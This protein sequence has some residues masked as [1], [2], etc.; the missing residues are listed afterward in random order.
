MARL[1]IFDAHVTVGHRWLEELATKLRIPLAEPQR[2]VLA[3]RAGLHAI[4]DRLPA[5]EVLDLGAQMPM[6]IR[7]LY[8]EGW[9]LRNDPTKI[10]T[11]AQLVER[12]AR[13]LR[14][15][16]R[17]DPVDVLRAVIELLSEHISAGELADVKATLPRTIAALWEDVAQHEPELAAARKRTKTPL[18][19]HTGYSR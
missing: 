11:R 17:L 4:R 1:H 5:G 7:G 12:V 14:G 3:L 9:T 15:A 19:R 10:R 13:E 2:I 16:A 18:V 8:I 6:L